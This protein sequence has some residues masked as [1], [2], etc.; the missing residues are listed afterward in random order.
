MSGVGIVSYVTCFVRTSH[1]TVSLQ[2][3]TVSKVNKS[4][5]NGDETY[6][7]EN[8]MILPFLDQ[9]IQLGPAK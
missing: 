8:W 2:Q 7:S 5:V 3:I 9:P 4:F 6:P 1:E